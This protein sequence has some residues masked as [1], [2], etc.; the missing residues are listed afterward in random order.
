MLIEINE[1]RVPF[2]KNAVFRQY[3]EIYVHI[4]QRF[5]AQLKSDGIEVAPETCTDIT[6]KCHKLAAK[7]ANVENDGK[8][9][10]TNWLSPACKACRTGIG[11]VSFFISLM[12]HKQCYYCFNPNQENYKFYAKHKRNCIQE[13]EHIYKSGQK[14]SY[15]ALTGGEPLLHKK[16]AIEFLQYAKQKFPE[17]HTRMYTTGELLD[18]KTLQALNNA[19]LNEIRFSIKLEDSREMQE[20]AYHNI[21]V[22]KPYIQDVMVEMP[23]IPGTLEQMKELLIRLDQMEVRGINL[24]EFCF[25]YH[26]T[27]EFTKR[28]FK[29][30][31]PPYKVLYDY[32][33]AGGLPVFHSEQECLDL[34]GFA[35]E[36]KLNIGVHYCSLENKH[37]GQVYQQNCHQSVSALAYLSPKDYFFKTAKVFESDV[38][39]VLAAFKKGKVFLYEYN[40]DY[41]FLEFHIKEIGQLKTLNVEVGISYQIMERR[42]DGNYLRELKV[43][44]IDW[45]RFDLDMV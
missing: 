6:E 19:G 29:V 37:T 12:C 25:P 34:I 21:M 4:Y 15:L 3:V 17:V 45:D 7:G 9:I 23:V 36:K 40:K 44:L 16:E 31:N 11:S 8:S 42:E 39:I 35:L 20:A 2:I 14:I 28:S 22:A 26:N 33:Y 5:F 43:A 27:A 30:K 18:E 10:Y 32:W 1:K 24:L 41:D 38:P 13:L